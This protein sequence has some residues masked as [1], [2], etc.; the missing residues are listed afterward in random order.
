[1]LSIKLKRTGKKKQAAFRVVVAEAR[2]KVGGKFVEDLGWVNPHTNKFEIKK[3]R[4]DYWIKNG[5]KATPTVAAY[6][7]K[8]TQTSP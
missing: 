7:R 6:L 1:M 5:A 2:S 8:A 4:A 3:E